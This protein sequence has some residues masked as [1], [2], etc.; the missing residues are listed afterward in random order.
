MSISK[1]P[2][3]RYRA[4][5][6]SPAEQRNVSVATVLGTPGMT[7]ATKKEAKIAREKARELL[8]GQKATVGVTVATFAERWTTDPIFKRPKE[9]TNQH[10]RERVKAFVDKFG[11]IPIAEI[12]EAIAADWLAQGHRSSVRELRVMFNDAASPAAGRMVEHNPFARLGLSAG[13]GRKHL[14]PPSVEEADRMLAIAWEHAPPGFAAWLQFAA[15]SGARPGEVDSLRWDRVD[16]GEN[17]VRI[18]DQWNAKI[19]KFTTPK[20]GKA[21]TIVLTPPAREALL[22]SPRDSDFCFSSLRRSHF[23]PSSRASWWKAVRVAMGWQK[24]GPDPKDLYL[25]T[26]HYCGWYLVNVLE[27]RSEDVAYQLGHEDD[28]ELVRSRY[29]HRDRNVALRK[30]EEAFESRGNVTPLRVIE[31]E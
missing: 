31:G 7:W 24:D 5:V 21:R 20:N 4:Q 30:I 18:S 12:D 28:G 1:L 17:R 22:R 11:D 19:R 23:T 15:Y 10:Y 9:S 3:N 26:R 29:G 8:T 16:M 2:S 25:C 13:K 14:N 27:M 6:W